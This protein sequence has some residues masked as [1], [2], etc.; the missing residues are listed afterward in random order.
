MDALGIS[1]NTHNPCV[2]ARALVGPCAMP[3]ATP[4]DSAETV[5]RTRAEVDQRD[6]EGGRGNP[7]PRKR[8]KAK[9]CLVGDGP[10]GKTSLVRRYVLNMYDDRYIATIGTKVSRK[11]VQVPQPA[12]RPV[13]VDLIIWDIMGHAGIRDLLGDAY[14]KGVSGVLAVCDM[15]HRR[16][17]E[18]L[19]A[20]MKAVESVAGEVAT[21]VAL[22]KADLEGAAEF[23]EDEAGRIA[24]AFG[25]EAL[26]T[27]ARTG[28]NVEEAFRLLASSVATRAL[29][30]N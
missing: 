11:E 4:G 3:P 14:F 29:H 2:K 15:T 1:R 16:S 20:W 19:E 12:D 18:R 23:G 27:S 30:S 7:P 9:I 17:L 5:T 28:E 25:G 13:T 24:D 22:N 26:A 8:L 10:V 6:R 21:L